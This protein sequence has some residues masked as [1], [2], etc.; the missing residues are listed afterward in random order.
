MAE[1]HDETEDLESN[2]HDKLQAL[3][4]KGINT[5]DLTEL[6]NNAKLSHPL[7]TVDEKWKLLPAFLKVRGLVKQHIDSFNYL[8]NV[9]IKKLLK[10]N[11]KV[12]SD[13][14]PSFYLK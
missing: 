10:A 9:E 7:S 2:F 4:L 6:Y 1:I 3:H 12:T 14:D 5:E 11:E 13:A 8:I